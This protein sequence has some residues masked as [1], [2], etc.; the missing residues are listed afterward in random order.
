ML[1]TILS[2]V[3]AGKRVM[4]A[5][6]DMDSD[7]VPFGSMGSVMAMAESI[8]KLRAVCEVCGEDATHTYRR[9]DCDTSQILVGEKDF[10][11]ARCRAHWIP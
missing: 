8:T 9:K 1:P 4:V 11:E 3:G 7:G 10:Y 5:G 2:L 6:L